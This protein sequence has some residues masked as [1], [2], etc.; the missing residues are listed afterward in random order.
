MARFPKPAEGSWT[1]HYPQLATEAVCWIRSRRSST[2]WSGTRSSGGH[3][4]RWVG[5]SR[6]HARATTSPKRIAAANT[7]II[8][9]ADQAGEVR[10]FHN[11]C[12]HRGNKLVWNDFPREET[13]GTAPAPSSCASTTAGATASTGR[14]CT[15]AQ[16][17]EGEF[18]DLD[19]SEYGLVPVH[20]DVCAGFIFV[21]L[22]PDPAVAAR[23]PRAH[24]HLARG[25]PVRGG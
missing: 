12:R 20:C 23:L 9:V 15:F 18:F 5:W 3:G 13:S 14:S 2:R 25:L 21:N 4:S 7:S 11:I 10:A 1:Q 6:F 8:V 24:D 17:Q 22:A 19:K 16:Q